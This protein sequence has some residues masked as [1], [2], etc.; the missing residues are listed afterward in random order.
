MSTIGLAPI[1]MREATLA[2][3]A[4]DYTTSIDQVIFTPQPEILWETDLSTTD[5]SPH[6]VRTVW[7]L[8]LGYAQDFTTPLSLSMY[9]IEHAGQQ[10]TVTLEIPGRVVAATVLIVPAQ[11]GGVVNQIPA[12]VVTLPMYGQPSLAE[13]P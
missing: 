5:A 4:D 2:I 6:L 3:E 12:A 9:L 1:R 13:V 11:L 7:S 10:K 8:S